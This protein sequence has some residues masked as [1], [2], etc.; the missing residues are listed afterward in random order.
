MTSC[1]CLMGIV[2]CHCHFCLCF[3]FDSGVLRCSFFGP[4]PA[5]GICGFCLFGENLGR[6][7]FNLFKI[8]P[9]SH[10]VPFLGLQWL[11]CPQPCPLSVTPWVT[12]GQASLSITMYWSLLKLTSIEPVMPSNHLILCGPFLLPPAVFPRIRVFSNELSLHH[13]ANVLE[14]QLQY[15]ICFQ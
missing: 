8:L 13:V 3:R 2:S 1:R 7:L 5:S 15:L 6:Y 11:F 9:R 4:C 12:A 10:P 14:L